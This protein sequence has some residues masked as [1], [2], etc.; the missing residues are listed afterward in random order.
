MDTLISAPTNDVEEANGK[1]KTV[2]SVG[3]DKEIT[4]RFRST[5]REEGRKVGWVVEKLMEA[6]LNREIEF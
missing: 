3:V 4:D 5:V 1:K 6:Y 2:F